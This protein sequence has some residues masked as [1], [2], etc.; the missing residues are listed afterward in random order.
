[1]Q[2]L[3]LVRVVVTGVVKCAPSPG[4]E[5][6]REKGAWPVAPSLRGRWY[7]RRRALS[8]SSWS[9][10]LSTSWVKPFS[11][12]N[13]WLFFQRL[14]FLF[15]VLPPGMQTQ[16]GVLSL[17]STS[18]QGGLVSRAARAVWFTVQHD[19]TRASLEQRMSRVHLM[20]GRLDEWFCVKLSW[21]TGSCLFCFAEEK[22]S[23]EASG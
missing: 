18:P 23:D 5:Q 20:R 9:L 21:N 12:L 13:R 17:V 19:P 16:V 3:C 10:D 4:A 2:P 1:M 15:G 7:H 11:R 6:A 22:R 8:G 14:T